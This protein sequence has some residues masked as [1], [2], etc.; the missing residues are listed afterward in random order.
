MQKVIALALLLSALSTLT[1]EGLSVTGNTNTTVTLPVSTYATTTNYT[2]YYGASKYAGNLTGMPS[3]YSIVGDTALSYCSLVDGNFSVTKGTVVSLS[4]TSDGNPILFYI[5]NQ[6]QFE[7]LDI[8][9]GSEGFYGPNLAVCGTPAFRPW[10]ALELHFFY[11]SYNMTWTAPSD[12]QYY[13]VLSTGASQMLPPSTTKYTFSLWSVGPQVATY[14]VMQTEVSQE[15]TNSS[16]SVSQLT[17]SSS[18]DIVSI[19]IIV[20]VVG[21]VLAIVW[22]YMKRRTK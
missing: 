4:M 19:A 14:T 12:G 3:W 11:T 6:A 5:M 2:T 18:P 7:T 15:S 13:W 1:L 8:H 16:S 9:Y 21:S 22:R 17:S 20:I 10:T